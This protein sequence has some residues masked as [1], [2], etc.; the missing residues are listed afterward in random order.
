M[1]VIHP[2]MLKI[3]VTRTGKRRPIKMDPIME[4]IS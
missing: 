1:E 4:V 2:A 3:I